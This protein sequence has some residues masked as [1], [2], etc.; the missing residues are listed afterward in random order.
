VNPHRWPSWLVPLLCWL[1][2]PFIA[3]GFGLL[4][5]YVAR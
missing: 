4:V 1:A 2:A 5:Y 3:A